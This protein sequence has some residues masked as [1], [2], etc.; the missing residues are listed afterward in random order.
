M[1]EIGDETRKDMPIISRIVQPRKNS[2]PFF[3]F[4]PGTHC[5]VCCMPFQLRMVLEYNLK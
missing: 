5:G 4:S 2:D 3:L 1:T